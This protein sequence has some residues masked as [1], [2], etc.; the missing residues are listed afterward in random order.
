KSFARQNKTIKHKSI[1][2]KE[3]ISKENNNIHLQHVNNLHAQLRKFLRPFN[4]VSSKYL[5]NYLNWFAYKDKLYGTKSTIKQW[6]YAILATPYAYEL[7]LQFKDNA[8]N[9]RT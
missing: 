5:Q 8:V 2:A 7:F 1:L 6:F 9:I 4:G 3:H